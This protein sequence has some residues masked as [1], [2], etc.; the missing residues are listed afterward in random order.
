MYRV[1]QEF[2]PPTGSEEVTKLISAA[3][4][5]QCYLNYV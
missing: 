1:S 3:E 4:V 5:I 2:L